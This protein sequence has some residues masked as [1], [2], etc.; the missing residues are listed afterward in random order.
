M[1]IAGGQLFVGADRF[2]ESVWVVVDPRDVVTKDRV[3]EPLGVGLQGVTAAPVAARSGVYC[4]LDLALPPARYVV[5]VRPLGHGK[6]RYFDAATDIDLVTVPVPGQPLARNPIVVQLFPRPEY[7]FDAERTLLRGRL[8]KASD[9][10]AVAGATVG[11]IVGPTDLG[12]R[13]RTD[14]RGAFAVCFPRSNPGTATGDKPKNLTY[15]LRF[16]LEGQPDVLSPAA[17]VLE[18]TM[19]VL[20]PVQFAGL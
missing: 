8:V 12:A 20:D 1:T 10:T 11:L 7:P 4:F 15:Q 9:Q 17:A 3:A 13:A 16:Q 5:Q 19:K 6:P 14:E 18:G 2:Q